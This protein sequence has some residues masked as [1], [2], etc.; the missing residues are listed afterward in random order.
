MAVI[1]DAVRVQLVSAPPN[2][3]ELTVLADGAVISDGATFNFDSALIG[4][5]NS[6]TFTVRNDGTADITL[7]PINLTGAAFSMASANFSAGQ[8]LT[9]GSSV[10]FTIDVDT[11]VAGT[12]NGT[13]AFDSNDGDESPFDLTLAATVSQPGQTEAI[14]DDGSPDFTRTGNWGSVAGYGYEN[15]A[16]AGNG[17][18]GTETAQWTFNNL[19]NGSYEVSTTWLR[20][21]DR[22]SAVTY[23]VRDGVGGPVLGS[24]VVD[25][26]QNPNGSV[27]GG[28]PFQVLNTFTI[29]GTTL[30][31]ELST[32]GTNM[33][34]IADAVRVQLV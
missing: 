4:D 22:E 5:N 11:S 27:H 31:V 15:D 25:Q 13:L 6:E 28:R 8:I 1:A 19:A 17:I 23:V 18:N 9:P 21:G 16:L 10:E 2:S 3:P 34:V 24:V 20:G 29:T 26:T 33:A 7:Q 30:V 32:T 14:L 12:F